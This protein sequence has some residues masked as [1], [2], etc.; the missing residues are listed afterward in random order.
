MDGEDEQVTKDRADIAE[1]WSKKLAEEDA[2]DLFLYQ[3]T[4][5][6]TATQARHL[7]VLMA[8]GFARR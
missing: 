4:G 3:I 8:R 1:Y 7:S 6:I 5:Q 2:E